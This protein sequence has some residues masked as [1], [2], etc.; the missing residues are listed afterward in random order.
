MILRCDVPYLAQRPLTVSAEEG[1]KGTE[2]VPACLQF[3]P[4]LQVFVLD[5]LLIIELLGSHVAVLHTEAALVHTPEGDARHRVV[6]ASRHLSAHILPAGADIAT[7]GSRRETLLASEA[8]TGE[9][10][11]ARLVHLTLP[12]RALTVVDSVGIDGRVSVEILRRGAEGRR[13]AEGFT[14]P[15]RGAVAH[16]RL[17]GI[18]PPGIDTSHTV[19][20]ILR[21]EVLV[22]L[23]PEHLAR[24][25]VV[26]IV[27]RTA[28]AKPVVDIVLH[29][30]MVH[31][32][33]LV[34]FLVVVNC[35]VELRP[36]GDHET[37]VHG[38]HTVEHR[39]RIGIAAGL[40]DMTAPGVEF[41]VVPVLYDVIH[42]D[43]TLAELSQVA[44]DVVRTLIALTALPEAQH[45]FRIERSL[46]RQRAIT[47]NH[48]VEILACDEIVVHVLGH[49]TPNGKLSALLSTARLCNPQTTIGLTAIRPPLDAHLSLLA[50][51]Q[52]SGELI[53]IGIPS[54]TPALRHYLLTVD[55]DLHIAR[56]VEYEL[57]EL[58][59]AF[60]FTTALW[61]DE[62]L[63]SDGGTLQV[64]ALGEVLNATIICLHGN[65]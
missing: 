1:D 24:P 10:E 18:H 33:I 54:R 47:R 26:G 37:S 65:L 4:L 56:I 14:I 22:H 20:I 2:L 15:H 19:L 61:L 7:P 23:A 27:E 60:A 45:P 36:Y 17:R 29:G 39:L 62:T 40:E 25:F 9:Q 11:H 34:E 41:P 5:T 12:D 44:L 32:A 50:L 64:E 55:I 51:L 53:A 28:E 31:P 57:I 30:L 6:Q 43:M 13:T 16:V 46:T 63:V 58:F 52:F 38:M 3:A 59:L 42:R 8:T 35:I 49:L 48:L 21:V